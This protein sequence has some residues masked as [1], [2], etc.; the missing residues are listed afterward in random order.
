M[1]AAA[2]LD[3]LMV[4]RGK[5]GPAPSENCG[6]ENDPEALRRQPEMWISRCWRNWRK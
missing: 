5:S 6:I 2:R 4:G 3:R 1:P